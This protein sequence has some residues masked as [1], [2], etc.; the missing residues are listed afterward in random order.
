MADENATYNTAHALKSTYACREYA[1]A[2]SAW[3]EAT[4][5]L[6]AADGAGWDF[7]GSCMA[8]DWVDRPAAE[9]CLEHPF[10]QGVA[11]KTV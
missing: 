5:F 2:D 10:L 9:E 3:E 6:G 8:P 7:L 4:A 1:D 11:V